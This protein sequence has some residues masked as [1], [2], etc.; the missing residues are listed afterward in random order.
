MHILQKHISLKRLTMEIPNQDERIA[1]V[2]YVTKSLTASN[3]GIMPYEIHNMITSLGVCTSGK[4]I[5]KIQKE[6]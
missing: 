3:P 4:E 6:L 2:K 5:Q 1:F